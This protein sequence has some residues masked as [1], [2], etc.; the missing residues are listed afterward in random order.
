[1]T[2]PEV[3][4]YRENG[5]PDQPGWAVRVVPNKFPAL[6]RE[7]S[8]DGQSGGLFERLNG[9]GAHEV[10]IECSD[11][12]DTL[13]TLSMRG[14]ENVLRAFL[15]RVQEL[16]QDRRF[17]YALLFKNHGSEAGASLEH[18]HSQL[19]A[20]PII[21]MRVREEVEGA[22]AYYS[23]RGSCIYC[24]IVA[25]EEQDGE[26]L[27]F[28]TEDFILATPYASRFPYETWILPRRHRASFEDMAKTECRELARILKTALTRLDN[29]LAHPPYN[30]IIHSSPFRE[31]SD[32]YY[33]WH[34]E[35]M[36]TL[37]KVAGFEWGTGVYINPTMPEEAAESL[38]DTTT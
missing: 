18:S 8:L 31:P 24:D 10:I 5:E 7:A 25:R 22:K 21:P 3:W 37:T 26:R 13:A 20:L 9:V 4:S 28:K 30:F 15:A 16:K 6:E 34:I 17:R 14:I 19:I 33:H 12:R 36:P 38:R 11:H 1:M 32:D 35:L 2:P 23:Q 27:I 29:L